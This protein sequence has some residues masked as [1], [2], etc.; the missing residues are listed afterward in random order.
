MLKKAEHFLKGLSHNKTQ[1]SAIPPEAYGERFLNFVT[2]I[3]MS[4]EE[5]ERQKQSQEQGEVSMDTFRSSHVIPRASVE[6]TM[7][8]AE[9]QA[10][11]SEKS[12]SRD[13][14]PGE[15]ILSTIRAP[16]TELTNGGGPSALPVV[17]EA[18]EAGSTGSRSGRSDVSATHRD[19]EIVEAETDGMANGEGIY[20][21][22]RT[23]T[24]PPGPRPRLPP[25][26]PASNLLSS[27]G[28]GKGKAGVWESNYDSV[29]ME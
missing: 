17:E 27:T 22:F 18:G 29:Q 21:Q 23:A 25:L 10:V 24:S 3:T 4:K 6:R 9:K 1:I 26:L 8:M 15:N 2:G 28:Y 14:E 19:G 16:S 11:K 7:E 5:V 12:P 13:P 20:Q